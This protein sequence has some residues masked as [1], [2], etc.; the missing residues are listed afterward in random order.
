MNGGSTQRWAY[1]DIIEQP[2]FSN[3]IYAKTL[4]V[5]YQRSHGKPRDGRGGKSIVYFEVQKCQVDVI[6]STIRQL[7]VISTVI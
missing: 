7:E 6:L 5:Q 1:L 4:P 3:Q 2:V